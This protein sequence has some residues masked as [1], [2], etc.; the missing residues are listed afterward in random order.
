MHGIGHQE[1]VE[2]VPQPTAGGIL[3]S[4]VQDETATAA[5]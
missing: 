1:K 4:G 5:N 2:K 3:A